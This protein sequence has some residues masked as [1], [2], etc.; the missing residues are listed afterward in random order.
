[1]GVMG[2]ATRDTASWPDWCLVGCLRGV[3]DLVRQG[4]DDE[5][6]LRAWQAYVA[7]AVVEQPF[8]PLVPDR[9]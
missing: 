7:A 5:Q 2:W 4:L 6:L 1:M 9:G 3:A 8:A